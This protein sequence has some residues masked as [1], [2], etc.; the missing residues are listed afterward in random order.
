MKTLRGV[1][2]PYW[3]VSLALTI[4]V[5]DLLHVLLLEQMSDSTITLRKNLEM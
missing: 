2:A 1:P 4:I 5:I 3:A